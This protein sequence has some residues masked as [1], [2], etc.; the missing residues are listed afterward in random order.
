MT[1]VKKVLIVDDDKTVCALIGKLVRRHGADAVVVA[2][3]K[4]AEE[5]LKSDTRF[6]AV[7]LDLVVP[8]VSGWD[9]LKRLRADPRNSGVPVVILSGA[10]LSYQEKAKLS[11]E[12]VAF[13]DKETF[14]LEKFDNLV[15]DVLSGR[16]IREPEAGNR[17]P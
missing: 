4:A 7:F 6:D 17:N 12:V 2:N 5:A 8:H 15:A 9:V 14:Q 3:G 13:V 1:A 11:K 16:N 10:P